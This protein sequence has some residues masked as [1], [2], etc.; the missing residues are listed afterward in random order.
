VS[1]KAG[2]RG[3]LFG[4]HRHTGE[5]PAVQAE[6]E[7]APAD[8]PAAETDTEPTPAAD[9]QPVPEASI[10]TEAEPEPAVEAVPAAEE[11]VTTDT[12]NGAEGEAEKPEGEKADIDAL[13]ARIRA[14][15]D[16]EADDRQAEPDSPSSAPQR[17][18]GPFGLTAS[19]GPSPAEPEAG[20]SVVTDIREGADVVDVREPAAES[21]GTATAVAVVDAATVASLFEQRDAHTDDLERQVG[22]RLKRAL[23]D[24]QNEV[25]DAA[26]RAKA[27]V[28]DDV[29][30]EPTDHRLQYAQ[31][32][33]DELAAA[34][35]AGREFYGELSGTTPK[36]AAVPVDD[37]AEQL[38][39]DLVGPLRDRIERC[40][41]EAQGDE[42]ELSDRLRALYREWKAQRLNDAA[43][44]AVLA[45]F[46]R[47]LY[48][49]VPSGTM[50]TWRAESEEPAACPDCEDNSLA[51]AQAK[52]E[53]FP[54]GHL[55]PPAHPGC[56][57]LLTPS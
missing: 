13:F 33:V 23:S 52:G 44:N 14:G 40:F 49:A 57:C 8:E 5:Q 15:S 51:G 27:P 3:R 20:G 24:E 18:A 10:A 50:L 19:G 47:G 2:K 12:A 46:D 7:P 22:R 43:R 6:P 42:F 56:R 30:P 39:S 26:R 9:S 17:T 37:L 25:L 29:V 35:A 21:A 48:A 45:A 55:S 16:D 41:A 11:P 54:T 1:A 53:P 31:A 4:R 38:A 32:A 36:G 34:A 28:F